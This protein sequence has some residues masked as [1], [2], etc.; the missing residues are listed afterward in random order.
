MKDLVNNIGNLSK[1][2]ERH[3]VILGKLADSRV[4]T[5]TLLEQQ[6]KATQDQTALLRDRLP[7]R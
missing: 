2:H 1:D 7:L 3:G 5:K 6:L 4:Q